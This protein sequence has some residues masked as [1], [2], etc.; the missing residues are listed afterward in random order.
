MWYKI[1]S[2]TQILCFVILSV[3][4]RIQDY[5]V[6][7]TKA[8]IKNCSFKQGE[9]KHRKSNQHHGY[10]M[11][12]QYFADDSKQIKYFKHQEKTLYILK[13]SVFFHLLKQHLPV[14]TKPTIF[15]CPVQY[16]PSTANFLQILHVFIS[17]HII[18]HQCKGHLYI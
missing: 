3:L 5:G 18:S 4:C 8:Y 14:L 2:F 1:F 6:I 10:R 7:Y 9:G 15:L 11:E 16:M 12:V 17:L 13:S